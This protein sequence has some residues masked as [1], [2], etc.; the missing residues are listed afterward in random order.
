MGLPSIGYAESTGELRA[1][2]DRMLARPMPPAYRTPHG[3]V[4]GIVQ[5]HSLDPA[6]LGSVFAVSPTLLSDGPLTWTERELISSTTSRINQCFYCT[7]CHT[8]FLRLSLEGA[9][10]L[11]LSLVAHPRSLRT[12]SPRLSVIAEISIAMTEAPWTLGAQLWDRA[13]AAGLDDDALVQLIMIC[14]FMCH[15]NRMADAVGIGLDYDVQIKPPLPDINSP[16]LAAAPAPVTNRAVLE[17]AR[18]PAAH[19]AF[20]AW[21][22][23]VTE[24]DAP[25]TRRQRTVIARWVALWLGDASISSPADLTANPIDDA[26]RELAEVVT[27]SPWKLSDASFARLRSHGMEDDAI[28]DACNTA[29][30]AGVISRMAVAVI[31]LGRQR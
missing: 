11:P 27:L 30:T 1:L 12:A 15:Q 20:T 8:E 2:Y 9:T 16:S 17:L 26:L 18:R 4:A 10:E 3:G 23:Y 22:S 14:A 7:A 13:H 24:R 19:A 29:S 6:L 21:R 5:A 25:L 28:F 31:A